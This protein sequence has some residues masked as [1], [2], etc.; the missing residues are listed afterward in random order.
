VIPFVVLEFRGEA[1][2]I[3]V[4]GLV[5]Y[6]LTKQTAFSPSVE[7]DENFVRGSGNGQLR[8]WWDQSM[9]SSIAVGGNEGHARENTESSN[10]RP[11]DSIPAPLPSLGTGV[12]SP[13]TARS[14]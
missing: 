12:N 8:G 7:V 6:S 14:V 10:S 1:S 11:G 4:A 5:Q 3:G 9:Q 2:D 13:S